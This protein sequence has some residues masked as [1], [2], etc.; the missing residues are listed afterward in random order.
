ML[1]IASGAV[2]AIMF[3]IGGSYTTAALARLFGGLLNATGG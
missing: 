2:S 3:G 1:S